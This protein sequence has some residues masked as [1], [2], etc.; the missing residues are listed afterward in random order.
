GGIHD[1]VA[2]VLHPER[3]DPLRVVARGA[4]HAH[5]AALAVVDV[6]WHALRHV[7]ELHLGGHRPEVHREV[8]VIHLPRERLLESPRDVVPAVKMK[9]VARDERRLEEGEALDVVPVNVA[10]EHVRREGHLLLE[11][12]PE[13]TQARPA[14]EDEDGLA[15]AHLDAARVAADLDRG[16]SR[17]GDAPSDSPESDLHRRRLP[18]ASCGAAATERTSAPRRKVFLVLVRETSRTDDAAPAP[19]PRALVVLGC[20]VSLDGRGRLE[21]ALAR[22]VEAAAEAYARR[23]EADAVV[24]ASGGR[25]C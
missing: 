10:E 21:G 22:R 16:R 25:R 19:S 3:E 12:L 17:R 4:R 8:R 24:V 18:L 11:L 9:H 15:R 14:V 13:E 2:L 23:G 20:R 7:E 6:E 5:L 1:G